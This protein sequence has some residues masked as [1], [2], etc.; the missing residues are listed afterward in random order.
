MEDYY[1]NDER[2]ERTW[3]RVVVGEIGTNYENQLRETSSVFGY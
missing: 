1:S 2:H 3:V